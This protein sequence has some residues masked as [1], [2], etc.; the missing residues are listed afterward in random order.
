[1]KGAEYLLTVFEKEGVKHVFLVPGMHVDPLVSAFQHFPDMQAVMACHEEGAAFMADGYAKVSGKFGVAAGI[2][3][4]GITNMVT[5]ITCAYSDQTPLFIITGETDE[6][7]EGRGAFQDGSLGGINDSAIVAPVTMRRLRAYNEAVLGPSIDMLMRAMLSSVARGPVHLAFARALQLKE[8]PIQPRKL[9][10]LS[11]PR[12]VDR[13]ACESSWKLFQGAKKIA[14][15]AGG[16]AQH[17]NATKE[18][19]RFAEQYEIPVATTLSAKSVFPEDHR[20]SLGVLGWYG[21]PYAF[22]TLLKKEID[23]L[24]VL[25]SRLNQVDT[26]KWS[27]DL[28]PKKAMII[29]DIN[30]S[31]Y[32]GNYFPDL[33]VLGDTSE[34]LRVLNEAPTEKKAILLEGS[35][36]RKKWIEEI[37]QTGPNYYDLENLTSDIVPIHPSRVMHELEKVMP[38]N[39]ILFSGEGASSF[40]ASHY[41]KCRGP[42]QHFT[43]VKYISS[44]GWSICAAIG[45]KLAKPEAPVVAIIGDGSMLMHGLEIQTAARY[46]AAVIFVLMNNGAHGNPQLRAKKIGVFEE[47]ALKLPVHDWAKVAEGLGVTGITVDQPEDLAPAFK[48]ALALKKPVLIDIRTGNYPTPVK[49]SPF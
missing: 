8:V 40:I 1:M 44:M 22:N 24:I 4:P 33:F 16:G 9:P 48:K 31:N 27:A 5:G 35:S 37:H 45:G 11:E 17:S 41:W 29:N 34:Y 18:L 38:H 7:W 12:L 36:E 47:N 46:Q 19:I 15:L 25:G 20:L 10:Y 23:V 30:E 26:A 2:A 21:N 39:T 42:R 3:G 43:Q 13:K 49:V 28:I 6:T 32:Y 14:I